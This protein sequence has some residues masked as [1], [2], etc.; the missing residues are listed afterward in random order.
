M[1]NSILLLSF[2]CFTIV[3]SACRKKIPTEH[4]AYIG[5]WQKG[6]TYVAHGMKDSIPQSFK[7]W[8]PAQYLE[9]IRIHSDGKADYFAYKYRDFSG[10]VIIRNEHIIIKGLIREKIPITC[11]PFTIPSGTYMILHN[12]TFKRIGN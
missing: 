8:T 4:E 1:K 10:R 12:D 7:K 5:N 11:S 2:L 3:F 9:N 6:Y